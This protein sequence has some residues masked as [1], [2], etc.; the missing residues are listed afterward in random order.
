[1]LSLNEINFLKELIESKGCCDNSN[2]IRNRVDCVWTPY[3]HGPCPI[4]IHRNGKKC[5]KKDR[6]EIAAKLLFDNEVE[7]VLSNDES[8]AASV[9]DSSN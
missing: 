9:S 2:R 5:F 1:M 7:E 3:H 8:A 6:I 4:S